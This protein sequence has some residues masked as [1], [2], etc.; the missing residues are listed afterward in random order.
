MIQEQD[1]I[2]KE[3][4]EKVK[5]YETLEKKWKKYK[6]KL[7]YIV[8][9]SQDIVAW[10]MQIADGQFKKY[11]DVLLD[12]LQRE[13]VDGECLSSFNE[14]DLDRLGI[15]LF[16]DKKVLLGHLKK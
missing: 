13:E 11:E 3:L 10:V 9:D 12:N 15:H 6:A 1:E 4:K 16:K 7:G 14:N 8:W 2:N 5:K